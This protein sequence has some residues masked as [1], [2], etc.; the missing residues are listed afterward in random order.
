MGQAIDDAQ[1]GG[2][3]PAAKAFKGFGGRGV[4]EIGQ[5]FLDLVELRAI[6]LRRRVASRCVRSTKS[7]TVPPGFTEGT[8]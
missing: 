4:I 5:R 6:R 1:W 2:E 3:H 8:C 7:T